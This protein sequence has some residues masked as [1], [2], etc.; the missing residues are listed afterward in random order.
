MQKV[1][2]AFDG[3]ESALRAIDYL[4]KRASTS[5]QAIE[6]H[7]VNVQPALH[8]GVTSFVK[9]DQLKQYHQDEGMKVLAPARERLEAAGVPCHIHLFVGEAAEV[10]ARFA[11]Q[12]GCDEIVVGTRGLS[13]ISG[14]L[15]GSIATKIVHLATVPVIL[16]K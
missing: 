8:G 2:L 13:G 7:V 6:V 12:E 3:S 15:L 11:S 10:I 16:V 4:G 5:A 14:M 1:L 9:A